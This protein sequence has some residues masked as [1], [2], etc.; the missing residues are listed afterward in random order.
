M[1]RFNLPGVIGFVDGTHVAI[2]NPG[3]DREHQYLNRKGY[4]SKNVQLICGPNNRV[5]AVNAAHGGASHDAFIWR[6][7]N[8]NTMLQMRLTEDGDRN[9]WL[10][11]DSGY[12]LMPYLLTPFPHPPENTPESRFNNAHRRARSC[13]EQ[14]IGI[15]KARFRCLLSE[16]AL[17]YSPPKAGTIINACVILHNIMVERDL[18]LPPEVDIL[19]AIYQHQ[20][21]EDD[22]HPDHQIEAPENRAAA[23]QN[24]ARIA[25]NYFR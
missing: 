5:Y 23:A 10:L 21:D 16:R 17:R 1:E 2:L 7:S 4:H 20:A 9:S 19:N 24:R 18:P 22:D 11:G 8:I 13:I 3:R 12:P 25:R 6:T 15:L 14:C